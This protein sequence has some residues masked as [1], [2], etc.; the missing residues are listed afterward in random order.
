MAHGV[1]SHEPN[2]DSRQIEWSG[3]VGV[4]GSDVI[5]ILLRM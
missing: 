3:F 1:F 2:L 5:V 4:V